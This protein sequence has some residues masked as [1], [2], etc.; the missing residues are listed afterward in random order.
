MVNA[1]TATID[2][3]DPSASGALCVLVNTFDSNAA[4]LTI[5]SS[6]VGG[7]GGE[8]SYKITSDSVARDQARTAPASSAPTT[9]SP[10][11]S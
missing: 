2:V 11:R 8:N 5:R 7:A 1:T 6:T 10:T 3:K 4:S 9:P